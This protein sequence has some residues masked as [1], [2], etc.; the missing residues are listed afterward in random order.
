MRYWEGSKHSLKSRSKKLKCNC[1]AVHST[2][3]KPG[4]R[5][6]LSVKSELVLVLMNSIVIE[7]RISYR[8]AFIVWRC[9]FG[10]APL[11]LRELCCP[12][13]SAMSLRSLRSSQQGLLLV[14]FARTSAKQSRA[15]SV[16]GPSLWNG[17][18]SQLRTLP[19]ALS[20]AFFP[21]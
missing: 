17:L 6:R 16:V 19:R 20:P 13:H 8:I 21:T 5:R 11:Y 9:L 2:P 15:F 10:L 12:L 4:V 3:I 14:P 1:K 18:A 7:Q